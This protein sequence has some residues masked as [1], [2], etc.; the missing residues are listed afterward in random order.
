[1]VSGSQFEEE[2]VGL[3]SNNDLIR[4]YLFGG[5]AAENGD[6]F[7]ELVL[8]VEG[9]SGGGRKKE[10]HAEQGGI[11]KGVCNFLHLW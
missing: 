7:L 11:P 1:M 2:L 8:Q 6:S 3:N 4:G 9:V 10:E 5:S